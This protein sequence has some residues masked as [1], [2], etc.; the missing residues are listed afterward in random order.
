MDH[1]EKV[2]H[3]KKMETLPDDVKAQCPLRAL[4]IHFNENPVHMKYR[5]AACLHH[6]PVFSC[7]NA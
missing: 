5:L 3:L 2:I 6:I 7:Q 1:A 4:T